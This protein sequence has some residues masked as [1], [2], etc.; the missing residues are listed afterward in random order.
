M[1]M[2]ERESKDGAAKKKKKRINNGLT[3]PDFMKSRNV[4]IKRWLKS[5]K[6]SENRE[7]HAD[8]FTLLKTKGQEQALKATREKQYKGTIV[9]LTDNFRSHKAKGEGN[10]IFKVLE[11]SNFHLRIPHLVKNPSSMKDWDDQKI[12]RWMV[13]MVV[14]QHECFSC[15]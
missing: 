9:Q 15:L 1:E 4:Q 12:Q 3:F 2:T 11:D 14:Q 5:V 8:S 6:E 10:S 7:A 13:V